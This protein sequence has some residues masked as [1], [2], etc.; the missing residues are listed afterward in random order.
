[1]S[2]G[3]EPK[4]R[5]FIAVELPANL[6]RELSRL[7]E[8]VKQNCN[9]CPAKWV[10]AANMHLTLSFLGDVAQ[11]RLDDIKTAM[12]AASA[13]AKPFELRLDGLGAFPN[14]ERPRVVWAGLSGDTGRLIR[15]QQ[16]LE[17]LLEKLGF[18]REQRLFSPHLTLARVRDEA[19]SS[20]KRRLGQAIGSTACDAAC[21]F[22]VESLHLIKSWLT[23]AGPIYTTLFSAG[24]GYSGL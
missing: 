21:S 7:Q 11:P 13:G 10:A 15:L 16:R 17:E 12:A 24:L 5:A 14:L 18:S 6:K 2:D 22:P 8:R 19:S 1:V 23:P 4:V 9:Y 20:D 3:G